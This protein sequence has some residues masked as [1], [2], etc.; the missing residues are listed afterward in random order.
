MKKVILVVIWLVIF[1]NSYLQVFAQSNGGLG[2]SYSDPKSEYVGNNI[3]GI[4]KQAQSNEPNL[5]PL[6]VTLNVCYKN[7]DGTYSEYYERSI[8]LETGIVLNKK[9]QSSNYDK[10]ADYALIWF[11][12]G[13]VAIVKLE[14]PILSKGP[15]GWN[16]DQI[17]K[18]DYDTYSMTHSIFYG[19]DRQGKTWKFCTA[20][21]TLSSLFCH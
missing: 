2:F 1:S 19:V 14:I 17:N 15:F 21:S 7:E 18:A 13:E 8:E 11:G 16:N 6:K 3:E 12:Y 9:T 10:N 4:T 20:T 5:S